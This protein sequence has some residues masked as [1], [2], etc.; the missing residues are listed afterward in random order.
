ML[1][2]PAPAKRRRRMAGPS[3]FIE[4]G[5]SCRPRLPSACGR[6]GACWCGGACCGPRRRGR[7]RQRRPEFLLARNRRPGS[8]PQKTPARRG[9][10]RERLTG[11]KPGGPFGC[12][13]LCG[14][15]LSRGAFPGVCVL[16][17]LF[18]GSPQPGPRGA[19]R[20][21]ATTFYRG[22]VLGPPP[23][24]PSRPGKAG[25]AGLYNARPAGTR[26]TKGKR[27]GGMADG[28]ASAR[29]EGKKEGLTNPGGHGIFMV[30]AAPPNERKARRL[31]RRVDKWR[32]P[33]TFLGCSL[34][35][36]FFVYMCR[37]AATSAETRGDHYTQTPW[38]YREVWSSPC[39]EW[40]RHQVRGKSSE[41][42][43]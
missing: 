12:R 5:P 19:A 13:L 30:G 20:K 24:S 4:I 22:C 18:C 9:V 10:C 11:P 14:R 1:A 28:A 26:R 2:K 35:R 41:P 40:T 42:C 15:A 17:V 27:W 29:R 43:R 37:R 36:S 34:G 8:P 32:K 39:R 7:G 16:P 6:G 38:G 3:F 31:V 23:V 25:R 21:M 33:K